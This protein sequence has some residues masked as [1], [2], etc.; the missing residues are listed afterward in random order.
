MSMHPIFAHC[1]AHR[2]PEAA[3]A[4]RAGATD[5]TSGATTARAS[6]AI[7]AAL[8]ATALLA[9]RAALGQATPAG[10][11]LGRGFRADAA[12]LMVTLAVQQEISIL[13]PT[14]G[15]S[16]SFVFDPELD[17]YERSDRMEPA[18]LRTPRLIG[19]GRIAVR[20]GAS[21]FELAEA[22][23]PAVYAVRPAGGSEFVGATSFGLD[24]SARVGVFNASATWG[25]SD[26]IDFSLNV[27]LTVVDA[28][29]SEIAPRTLFSRPFPAATSN[30][31]IA[32]L[33]APGTGQLRT[34]AQAVAQDLANGRTFL[35]E[36]NF[37]DLAERGLGTAF[38]GGTR[39]GVGRISL[40]VKTSL[41]ATKS[42]ES[43]FSL[44]TFLPSPSEGDFSGTDTGAFVPRLLVRA[45]PVEW[46]G[47]YTDAG[48]DW[49]TGLDELRGFVWGAGAAVFLPRVT[50]DA[51]FTGSLYQQGIE[52]TPKQLS[53]VVT[54]PSGGTVNAEGIRVQD[55]ELGTNLVDF[56]FGVKF[57]LTP[58]LVLSGVANVPV[59]PD[60]F[61][62]E[63]AGTLAI[64]GYF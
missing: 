44:E 11:D 63:A 8:L 50:L 28:S 48:Y 20:L 58:S 24:A 31:A 57:A 35:G 19:K 23:R 60:G 64:E 40:G 17:T 49:D 42:F 41:L 5:L 52:Y 18:G 47:L 14:S 6:I 16:V 54:D 12:H 1:S 55:A 3:A 25:Y 59:T 37:D 15:Q 32:D 21:Y 36:G 39:V 45:T 34:P 13:P 9:P 38:G 29:A 22:F 10:A 53:G 33:V 61:R 7:A 46:L 51:G 30:I 26:T 43:A 4:R 56:V 2:G 62:P 27:P